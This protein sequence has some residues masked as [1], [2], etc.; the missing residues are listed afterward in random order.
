MKHGRS[1]F[2]NGWDGY[3]ETLT[4]SSSR[5]WLAYYILYMMSQVFF[6]VCELALG[7]EWLYRVL[8]A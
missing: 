8:F 2:W 5:G 6:F 4:N 3:N 7:F 1:Y